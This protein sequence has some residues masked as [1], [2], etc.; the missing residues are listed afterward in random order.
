MT[1]KDAVSLAIC[2]VIGAFMLAGALMSASGDS[3]PAD[4]SSSYATCSTTVVVGGQTHVLHYLP[5]E[6]RC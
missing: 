3:T 1:A 6:G 5:T 4:K 2:T